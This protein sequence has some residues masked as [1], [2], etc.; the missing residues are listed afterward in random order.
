MTFN[1]LSEIN[2]TI[3]EGNLVDLPPGI[4]EELNNKNKELPYFFEIYTESQLRSFVGV[5]QFTSEKDTIEI[6]Y[7]LSEQLGI[8]DGNQ[9]IKIELMENVPKG[10]Y[11]KLRP[12]SEDFFD[13][14]EYESCLETKLSYFPLLHQGQKIVINLFDKNYD[15]TVEEIEHDWDDFDFELGTNSL[16][17][18]VI[19]VIDT[20]LEVDIN[21]QYLRKKLE[22]EKKIQEE[23]EKQ[24]KI[25]QELLSKRVLQK[26]RIESKDEKPSVFNGVGKRLSE[27][28]INPKDV[29]E[30]RLKFLEKK[31]KSN[32]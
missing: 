23:I 28:S 24:K 12:E 22:E 32:V 30:A 20:D 29:K 4:L 10:K 7:W 21:N 14:P 3:T 18:N 31:M 13:I 19:N 6:P 9:I 25:Q 5:R 15:I 16:E 11:I 8:S 27:E 26:A 2:H 17:K 1:L